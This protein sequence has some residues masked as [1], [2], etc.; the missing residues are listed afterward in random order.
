M[1][2]AAVLL[3]TK[4]AHPGRVKTRLVGEAAAGLSAEQAAELHWAF[5]T[6]LI[7]RLQPGDFDLHLTWALDEGEMPPRLPSEFSRADPPVLRQVG[8]SLGDRLWNALRTAGERYPLVAAIGSDHPELPLATVERALEVL[9]QGEDVAIGPALDGGYYLI[10][11]RQGVLNRRLF[12]DVPWSTDGVLAATLERCLELG[13]GV[14]L[15]DEASD[16]DRP[17]DLER[18]IEHLNLGAVSAPATADLLR[19]WRLLAPA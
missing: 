19:S 6:D 17:E 8:A 2:D 15:L 12:Q 3:F 10:A 13:L 18:L 4:P 7:A 16:V 9:R 5:V 1:Q 11:A 14:E